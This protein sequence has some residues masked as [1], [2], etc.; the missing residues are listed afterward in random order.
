MALK[1]T[2][3]PG[4]RMIIGGAVLTN[5]SLSSCDLVIENK[6]PILRQK[7]ILTEEKANSPCRRIYYAI[8]LMYIDENNLATYHKIY[9]DLVN[10]LVRAAP[11][12]VALIDSIN[13][14]ILQRHYYQALKL[15]KKLIEYEQ[16]AVERV[17]GGVEGI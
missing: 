16:E 12:T 15:T 5:G 9:W 10:D 14:H 4:E 13:E 8:Q 6:T 2:L 3:K 17:S 7:D 11:T 1:I